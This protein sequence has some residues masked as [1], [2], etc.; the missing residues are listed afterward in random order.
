MSQRNI[1]ENLQLQENDYKLVVIFLLLVLYQNKRHYFPQQINQSYTAWKKDKSIQKFLSGSKNCSFYGKKNP[2]GSDGKP[3]KCHVCQSTGYFVKVCPYKY[4]NRKPENRSDSPN[5]TWVAQIQISDIYEC[6]TLDIYVSESLNYMILATGCPRNV[7]GP[8]WFNCFIDSLSD[9]LY[10]EVNKSNSTNKFKFGGGKVV[11]SLFKVQAPN[12][13]ANETVKLSFDVVD[14]DIPLL[15]DKGTRKQWNFTI[16]TG[17]DSAELTIN[18]VTHKIELY[19]LSDGHWCLN[20][21]PSFPIEAINFLFSTI[22]LSQKEKCS[23]A[24]RIHR[25]LSPLT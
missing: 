13:I 19:T 6:D 18:T 16:F 4:R 8:V 20:I 3:L 25:Q 12:L 7:A 24:A 2:N 15:L 21:Q 11:P 23:V 10:S 22:N 1:L 14:S 5:R 17:N 9:N